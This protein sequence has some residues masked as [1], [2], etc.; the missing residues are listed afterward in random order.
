MMNVLIIMV[1]VPM[2]VSTQK[3]A[4]IVNVLLVIPFS[5]TSVIV[6]VNLYSNAYLK[7]HMLLILY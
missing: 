7:L 6:K 3:V 5:P 2:T 4:I 1:T